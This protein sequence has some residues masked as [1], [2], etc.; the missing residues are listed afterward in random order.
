M[1]S[2]TADM[3]ALWPDLKPCWSDGLKSLQA[4]YPNLPP[5]VWDDIATLLNKVSE[6]MRDAYTDDCW[7]EPIVW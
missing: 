6:D 5:E 1:P 2:A 3:L 7:V 4:K